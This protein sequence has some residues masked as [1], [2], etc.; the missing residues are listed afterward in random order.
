MDNEK[1]ENKVIKW[2]KAH[3]KQIL[4]TALI[5][6]GA[7]LTIAGVKKFARPKNG[8]YSIYWIRKNDK[9][10][11]QIKVPDCAYNTLKAWKDTTKGGEAIAGAALGNVPISDLGKVG[12]ELCKSE[13]INK[14]SLVDLVL[15]TG[16]RNWN[17]K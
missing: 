13:E 14:N 9:A 8:S 16:A 12:E 7:A 11:A 3:K 6:G 17:E 2:V 4:M 5:T 10:E 15:T 1:K